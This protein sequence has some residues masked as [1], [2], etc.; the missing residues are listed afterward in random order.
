[1]VDV[2][3]GDENE[4]EAPDVEPGK[5]MIFQV[6]LAPALEH[7]AIYCEACIFAVDEMAGSGHFARRTVKM[8]F[9]GVAIVVFTLIKVT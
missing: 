7:S 4:I 1:M 5:L 3:V 9:H 6:G 2:G 8:K